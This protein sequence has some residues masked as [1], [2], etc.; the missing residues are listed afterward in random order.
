M[1]LIAGYRLFSLNTQ[2]ILAWRELGIG[3]ATL[4]IEDDRDNLGEILQRAIGIPTAMTVYASVPL[5]SSRIPIRGVRG[6]TPV[7]SDRGD[8]YP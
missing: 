8:A 5:L 2:A 1:Q 3:E 6:D 4:Y 7:V